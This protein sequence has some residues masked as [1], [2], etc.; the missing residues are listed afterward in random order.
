MRITFLVLL[1]ATLAFGQ[2]PIDPQAVE[3]IVKQYILQ[4]PEVLLE[5]VRNY[6]DRQQAAERQ[7]SSQAVAAHRDELYRG[8]GHTGLGG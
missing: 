2:T 5:S 1:V 6:Q 4:H 3:Q 8:S 7:K